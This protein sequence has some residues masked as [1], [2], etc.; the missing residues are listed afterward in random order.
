MQPHLESYVVNKWARILLPFWFASQITH[1][2]TL[3]ALDLAG[4]H[5]PVTHFEIEL[6]T[7]AVVLNGTAVSSHVV[8]A[9][10]NELHLLLH[11]VATPKAICA[12]GIFKHTVQSAGGRKTA[13]GCLESDHAKQLVESF[14]RLER[15]SY[16]RSL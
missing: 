1:A 5:G 15:L 6:T 14:R 8:P 12:A 11:P 7:K 2:N 9:I 10:Q 16:L 3:V 13:S 4:H